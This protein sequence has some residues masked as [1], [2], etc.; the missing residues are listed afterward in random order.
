MMIKPLTG[1]KQSFLWIVLPVIFLTS[2]SAMADSKKNHSTPT[3]SKAPEVFA[4]FNSPGLVPLEKTTAK[5]ESTQGKT[6]IQFWASWC[7]GCKANMETTVSAL[8]K[9]NDPTAARY[10]TVSLDENPAMAAGYLQKAGNLTK[11]LR[12]I[13]FV[14]TNQKMAERLGITAVPAMILV[15]EDGSIAAQKVGHVDP[16]V[17]STFIQ[18][19]H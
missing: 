4:A 9:S 2:H 11:N 3:Q 5:P 6:I 18:P 19:S 17:I 7:V 14:D 16:S 1:L 13:T 15:N 10:I 8:A 12:E